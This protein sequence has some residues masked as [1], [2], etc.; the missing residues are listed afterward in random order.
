MV[1]R[2]H[3]IKTN[4]TVLGVTTSM[5]VPAFLHSKTQLLK[6]I[7]ETELSSVVRSATCS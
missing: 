3:Q 2:A 1:D 7:W 6:E 4:L 5:T